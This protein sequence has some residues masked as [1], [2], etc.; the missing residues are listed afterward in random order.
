L[1]MIRPLQNARL[2]K[3]YFYL[4]A[5]AEAL[6]YRG[7]FILYTISLFYFLRY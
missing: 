5:Q 4:S 7:V 2:K 1:A 6:F 3:I